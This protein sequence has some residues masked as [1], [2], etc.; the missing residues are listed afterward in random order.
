MTWRPHALQQTT[1][2]CRQ[3]W[4][5]FGGTPLAHRYIRHGVKSKHSSLYDLFRSY[6]P[7]R[8]V[9]NMLDYDELKRG[10][11]LRDGWS[12]A[13]RQTHHAWRVSELT[14]HWFRPRAH[15]RIP[16]QPR[17]AS[18]G[19]CAGHP[20]A[21]AG[22]ARCRHQPGR[23]QQVVPQQNGFSSTQENVRK[24]ISS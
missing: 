21:S 4:W 7:V 2:S 17:R 10:A 3:K 22:T 6:L 18:L 11:P 12:F 9:T 16:A 8:Y 13:L 24:S 5:L 14:R 19:A 20:V 1:R 15:T 23:A